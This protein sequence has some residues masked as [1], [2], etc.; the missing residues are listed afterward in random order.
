MHYVLFIV[1]QKNKILNQ[2]NGFI[3]LDKEGV[4]KSIECIGR[5]LVRKDL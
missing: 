2:L 1:V 3:P 5:V 4:D